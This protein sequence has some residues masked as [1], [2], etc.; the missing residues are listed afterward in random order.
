VTVHGVNATTTATTLVFEEANGSYGYRAFSPLGYVAGHGNSL[1]VAG[2]P[3]DVPIGFSAVTYQ[4]VWKAT[5]LVA[6]FSWAISLDGNLTAANGAWLTLMLTNGSYS[7]QVSAIPGFAPQPRHGTIRL[8]G[9]GAIL[10]I[11]FI[12]VLFPVTFAASGVPANSSWQVRLANVTGS[13]TGSAAGF[14]MANGTYTYDVSAP[15]GFYAVPSHGTVTVNG[16]A[17]VIP[18]TLHPTGVS[19]PPALWDLAG[20]ALGAAAAIGISLWATLALVGYLGRRDEARL[21]S[22]STR[23]EAT[24]SVSTEAPAESRRDR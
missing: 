19:P 20:P 8:D 12:R 10:E 22:P 9:E 17:F 13:T 2:G 5:G 18:V 11:T 16:A 24:D 7:F 23:S 4:V 21:R 3:L 6:N 14:L 15:P 1:A